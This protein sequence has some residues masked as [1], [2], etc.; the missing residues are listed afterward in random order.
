MEETCVIDGFFKLKFISFI[1]IYIFFLFNVV[2]P[3]RRTPGL[4]GNIMG[5]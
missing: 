3:A 5:F 1:N 2:L 4:I